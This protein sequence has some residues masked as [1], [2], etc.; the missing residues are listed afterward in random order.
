E[1]IR[2]M[3][4]ERGRVLEIDRVAGIRHHHE[5]R[6]R[7]IAL[8]QKTRLKAGPVLVPG[9]DQRGH[10]HG[11]GRYS[12]PPPLAKGRDFVMNEVLSGYRHRRI[13]PVEMPAEDPLFLMYTSG[14]TGRP[15][16]CQHSTGGYCC[17]AQPHAVDPHWPSC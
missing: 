15:K 10:A 5:R 6:R 12:S 2:E 3:P 11:P 8:H 4:V 1:E 16:G 17:T 14:T 7:N 9:H 13:D